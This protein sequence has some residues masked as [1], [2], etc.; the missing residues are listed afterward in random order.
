[1]KNLKD[2][3]YLGS[4]IFLVMLFTSCVHD[5]EYSVPEINVEEPN[6]DVNTNITAVKSIYRGYEPKI[7]EAG[8]GSNRALYL[9]A[10]VVSS[11]ETGNFYKSLVIQ[12]TP[13]NPTAGIAI[14]T[15]ATNLYTKYEPGRKIYFRVDGLYI[16]EYAA[17]PSIGILDGDEIG[18]MNI[19]DFDS[20]ILRSMENVEIIPRLVE[21]AEVND[22][23]TNADFLNTLV[24][25]ENIQFP[26]GLAGVAHYGNP[27]NTYSVNRQLEDCDEE[28]IT[29]RTSGFSDFKGLLLPEG[30]GS[31]IAVL[32]RFN[33]DTQLFIRDIDD[34]DFNGERC[35]QIGA[36]DILELPFSQDFEGQNSGDD[37]PV[38][39]D[40][41]TNVNVNGGSRVY[42][43][44]EFNSNNYAQTSA[45]SSGES[46]CEV[47]LVT[48]GLILP[49][50]SSPILAFDTN[51][52]FYNGDAL[53]IKISIDFAE[54]VTTADWT[55]LNTTISGGHTDGYGQEFTPSGEIDL[56]AY[57][58][59]VVHIAFQY[60]GASN[61]TTTTYQIDNI[62]VVE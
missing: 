3:K 60:L 29:L 32:S 19:E 14:S 58:G 25:F 35:N 17:L 38:N 61:G 62:S 10:Y 30:N 43:V 8:D 45:R 39:I 47:W 34:V 33:N 28:T 37:V 26:D 9:E 51:D 5:D 31:L 40:G 1:M 42:E 16:G 52:G 22:R 56:T 23:N 6:V 50:D 7:I 44:K 54:D 48:P 53:T 57:A 46:P 13:E 12:D 18:R 36:G 24:R 21:V 4:L 27:S 55:N 11:D 41:W 59:Q 15:E 20:R 49:S 2:I